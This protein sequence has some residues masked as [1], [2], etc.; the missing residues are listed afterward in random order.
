MSNVTASRFMNVA[1]VYGD[2]SFS[3]KDMTSEALYELAAPK[4]PLE[5]REEVEKMIEARAKMG[6]R[7]MPQ[8]SLLPLP[9]HRIARRSN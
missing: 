8:L 2:K 3:L 1:R 9:A 6:W 7:I 5:V 4:T